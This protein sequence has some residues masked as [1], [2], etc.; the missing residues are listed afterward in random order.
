[1]QDILELKS[2]LNEIFGDNQEEVHFFF[3]PGRVNLIGDHTDYNGG[4]VMPFALNLGTYLAI[5]RNTT[6]QFRIASTSKD[7]QFEIPADHTLLKQSN[8]WVNYP[9]GILHQLQN[10]GASFMGYDMLF[11]SDLPLEAGLSSS[12]SIE[13]VTAV[14]MNELYD[15]QH[16][17]KELA[18]LCQKAE[19]EFVGMPCG[20]MDQ[21][22]SALSRKNTALFLNCG[23]MNYTHVPF[24][25]ETISVI[26]ANSNV[27]RAL[28]SSHYTTRRAECEAA[29]DIIRSQR[30]LKHIGE[31]HANDFN[32]LIPL[33]TDETLLKR[34]RHVVGEDMRVLTAA[35][36]M[37]EGDMTYLGELMLDS[38][39][40]LRNDYEV[41]CPELDIL[42]EEAYNT[43][44]TLGSR[45]TGAGFG[46]CTVNLV[47]KGREKEFIEK[48]GQQYHERTGLDADFYQVEPGKSAGRI[49]SILKSN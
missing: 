31:L 25:P 48:V 6:K 29:A 13:V 4:Y 22:A 38:H 12:A 17:P 37:H 30:P 15:L 16:E 47:N 10:H 2:K 43:F 33:F 21:F 18:L 44:L 11:Y 14:A 1:M 36:A 49:N 7:S 5:R 27:K 19:N 20:I 23:T 28:M 26:L 39:I 32:K 9:L 35:K 40:S 45:M 3:A 24:V 41:S 46:G 8:E 42:V 34:L